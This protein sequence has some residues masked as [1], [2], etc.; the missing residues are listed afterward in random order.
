[1]MKK[2]L[3]RSNRKNNYHALC[4]PLQRC[5]KQP[6]K[7][8]VGTPFTGADD[9]RR[10][11]GNTVKLGPAIRRLIK[12]DGGVETIANAIWAGLKTGYLPLEIPDIG[13]SNGGG[14]ELRYGEWR[15]C[16]DLAGLVDK[17]TEITPEVQER[18]IKVFEEEAV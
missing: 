4:H 16:L 11:S 17:D 5:R 12:A 3:T 9:P 8:K 14:F 1:M 13:K 2:P 10:F 18:L 15:D 6:R 7:K